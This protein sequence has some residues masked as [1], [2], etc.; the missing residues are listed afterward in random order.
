MYYYCLI[1]GLNKHVGLFK[2][3]KIPALAST[4][5]TGCCKCFVQ[6]MC[7]LHIKGSKSCNEHCLFWILPVKAGSNEKPGW[8]VFVKFCYFIIS[9]SHKSF[10]GMKRC[11][12]VLIF[13]GLFFTYIMEED[14]RILSNDLA[15][16]FILYFWVIKLVFIILQPSLLDTV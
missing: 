12:F 6:M 3:L 7:K 13:F 9:P 16:C 4:W 14:V 5:G 10:L 2:V 8:G 11:P 1:W 15:L